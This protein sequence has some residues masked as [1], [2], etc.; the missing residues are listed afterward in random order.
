MDINDQQ[1]HSLQLQVKAAQQEFD[2][3]VTF[4]EVWKPTAYDEGLLN[5]MG[6]SYSSQAFLV[7]KIALRREMLL[8]LMR[9]WDNSKRSVKI[10]S[11]ANILGKKSVINALAVARIERIGV[12]I[13]DCEG[14][15][16]QHL[17]DYVDEVITLV[18]KYSK[19]GSHFVVL[20]KL[21]TLRNEHL[22]HRQ[23]VIEVDTED[24]ATDEEVET[25]YQDNST[26][27]KL[28]LS[29]V[30][31]VSYDPDDTAKVFRHYAMHFWAGVRGERTAGHPNYR[32]PIG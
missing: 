29:I 11:V 28:L 22:A 30:L 23:Q 6:E 5:R 24:G 32:E 16:R 12:G 4:H 31:G 17:S 2:L 10:H 3:A 7:V 21:Q 19:G 14:Q 13:S 8:A 9:L 15:M 20:T 26:L 25:F 18:N 27:I 1:I